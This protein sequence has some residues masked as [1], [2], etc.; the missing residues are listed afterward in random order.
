MPHRNRSLGAL[1]WGAVLIAGQAGF[2]GCKKSSSDKDQPPARAAPADDAATTATQA[3]PQWYRAALVDGQLGEIPFYLQVPPAPGGKA[4]LAVGRHE[5]E[6]DATWQS[7]QLRIA[8]PIFGS[9]LVAKPAGEDLKG[10]WRFDS[11]SW[12]K[13]EIDFVAEPIADRTARP[14]YPAPAGETAI[15]LGE[16]RTVWR[17]VLDDAEPE[18][19]RAKL[20]IEQG[21]PGRFHAIVTFITG[22]NV[23]LSGNGYG[24]VLQLSGFDGTSPYYLRLE[25]S[26]EQSTIRGQ[27]VAGHELAWRET[28]S[29]ERT[30]DYPF[31]PSVKP[32][33]DGVTLDLAE[34]LSY[35]GKPVL[36]ELGGSWCGA[37]KL[38]A[39]LMRQLYD[40]YHPRGVEFVTLTYEFTD[41]ADHNRAKADEF[42]QVYGI[43]W[44]VVPVDGS[45]D[46]YWDIIP[47]GLSDFDV[48]N[49]PLAIFVRPDGT[50]EGLHAGAVGP[51]RRAEYQHMVDSYR[52]H[53]DALVNAK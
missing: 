52:E 15:D 13:A 9:E 3:E 44:P 42:K 22:N 51:E 53:L 48:T 34:I 8:W 2:I 38:V 25:L 47:D 20:V 6:A 31:E 45:L 40:E 37:C 35:R 18:K 33:K 43:Q 23:V 36:V 30:D 12:G 46:K 11:K 16:E 39:P 49:L 28:V 1:I 27:W 7:G 24:N 26:D 50:I 5:T 4:Q 19:N 21:E 41:D 10:S 29:G 17:T 14:L 32:A